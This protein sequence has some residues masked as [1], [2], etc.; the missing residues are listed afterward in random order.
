MGLIEKLVSCP[1]CD[2]G[3]DEL[4]PQYNGQGDQW[5]Q[6]SCG[7]T[8]PT[9]RDDPVGAWNRR[10]REEKWNIL[11]AWLENDCKNGMGHKST[12]ALLLMDELD[13]KGEMSHENRNP[14]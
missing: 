14:V 10:A 12:R 6:C 4:C 8:G 7:A 3:E 9:S 11:R 2:A 13:K 5:V 1:F